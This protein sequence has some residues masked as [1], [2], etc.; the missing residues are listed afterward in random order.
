MK[1]QAVILSI[2]LS[3]TFNFSVLALN[4]KEDPQTVDAAITQ[5]KLIFSELHLQ[6]RPNVSNNEII[7]GLQHT[8]ADQRQPESEKGRK[9]DA[10]PEY[11][12]K[13]IRYYRNFTNVILTNKSDIEIIQIQINI[14]QDL[15]IYGEESSFSVKSEKEIQSRNKQAS[16]GYFI[17]ENRQ[18]HPTEVNTDPML[19]AKDKDGMNE[20]IGFSIDGKDLIFMKQYLASLLEPMP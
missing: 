2:L 13:V 15:T 11:L 18:D 4:Q 5:L 16:R 8:L 7:F 20:G 17:A 1:S 14:L 6:F 12:S 3:T 10:T 9:F 19:L